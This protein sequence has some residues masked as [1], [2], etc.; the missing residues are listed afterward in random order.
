MI[1]TKRLREQVTKESKRP[2]DSMMLRTGEVV[3]DSAVVLEI[4]NKLERYE[5]FREWL[6]AGFAGM[7]GHQ[8]VT[9]ADDA[10]N[11]IPEKM[12][13]FGIE[14]YPETPTPSE[15]RKT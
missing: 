7:F 5:K 10:Y 6:R 15:E 8:S 2:D 13:E 14:L 11:L 4:L 3:M 12:K 9:P 1:D